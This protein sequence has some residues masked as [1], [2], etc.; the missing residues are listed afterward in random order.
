MKDAATLHET[1]GEIAFALDGILLS[2]MST[3]ERTI[4]KKLVS[5]EYG[6]VDDDRDGKMFKQIGS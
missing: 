4:V 1:L 5:T 3:A 6:Y 2:D